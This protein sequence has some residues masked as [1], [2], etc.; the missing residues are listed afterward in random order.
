MPNIMITKRCNLSC[1]YCFANKFVNHSTEGDMSLD[2]LKKI[3]GFLLRDGSVQNVG[4]IG[5]EPSCHRQFQNI[6]ELLAGEDRLKQVTLYTNGILLDDCFTQLGIEKFKVLINCNEPR[7]MG[8]NWEKLVKTL[9]RIK[10]S[11]WKERVT[12]GVNFYAPDFDYMYMLELVE[13]FAP[14]TLRVSVSVP[15]QS[16]YAYDPFSYFM[17]M[18]PQIFS[19]F[20]ELKVRNVI[21]FFDCNVFPACLVSADEVRQFDEWGARNPFLHL[22]NHATGCKPVID[23]M[24][25]MTAVR[26]F[27][28]SE[29]TRV[30]IDQFASF[31][32]LMNYYLRHVDAYAVNTY[33]HSKCMDCYQYK[34]MRCSGGCLVYKINQIQ[35]S[36]KMMED[37]NGFCRL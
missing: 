30:S 37:R 3:L 24:D 14:E 17:M 4:L 12:L 33:Y 23:I 1:P 22:K 15:N 35:E 18:K 26:C 6:L 8:R 28:L 19:F 25:D 7:H 20:Q 10:V 27:G 9:K 5:G 36:R 32:D 11:D 21:P 29:Y 13:I 31:T 34:T 2:I 16:E